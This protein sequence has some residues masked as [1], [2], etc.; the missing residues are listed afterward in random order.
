MGRRLAKTN[1]ISLTTYTRLDGEQRN[2]LV[3]SRPMLCIMGHKIFLEMLHSLY[4]MIIPAQV[5]ELLHAKLELQRI[6]QNLSVQIIFV[7][8]LD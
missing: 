4:G 7:C 5:N 8:S 2:T 1:L 6:L 3:N